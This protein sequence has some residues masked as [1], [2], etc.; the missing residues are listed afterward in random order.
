MSAPAVLPMQML[1]IVVARRSPLRGDTAE[2]LHGGCELTLRGGQRQCAKEVTDETRERDAMT[3][4]VLLAA[5]HR[6][7]VE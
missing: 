4:S 7:G 3:L 1:A 2:P 6:L 5:A